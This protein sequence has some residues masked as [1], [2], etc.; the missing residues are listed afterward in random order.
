MMRCLCP[1]IL[2]VLIFFSHQIFY[3]MP[4]RIRRYHIPVTMNSAH[5]FAYFPLL[6]KSFLYC[7]Y[8]NKSI[9]TGR[10]HNIIFLRIGRRY[11][12]IERKIS[13]SS[14]TPRDDN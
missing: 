3:H 1:V 11:K 14:A 12:R 10:T 13:P 9:I 2:K 7:I 4:Q 6:F 8:G 5:I